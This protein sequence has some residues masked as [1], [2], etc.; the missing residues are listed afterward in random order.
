MC[1]SGVCGWEDSM[2]ECHKPKHGVCSESFEDKETAEAAR[3][4]AFEQQELKWEHQKIKWE[5]PPM[6]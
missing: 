6:S 2:G 4:A 3:I 1:N 5:K